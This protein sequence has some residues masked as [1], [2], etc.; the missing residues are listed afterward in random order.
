MNPP[1]GY[2][3]AGFWIRTWATAI[4]VVVL[5]CVTLPL[6]SPST[7]SSISESSSLVRG[8]MDFLIS[9]V[10]PMVAVIVLWKLTSATPG[11]MLVGAKIVDARTGGPLGTG[12]CIGRYFAYLVSILPL[13]LGFVWIAFDPRKQAWHD[14]LAGTVVVR[15]ARVET[16]PAMA[17]VESWAPSQSC[18]NASRRR[19]RVRFPV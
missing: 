8:P 18:E 7:A 3:Y 12:Q 4:D 6:C 11:K 17:N 13:G 15:K 19:R 14:K 5:M 16:T 9:W 2:R 10:M 1:E